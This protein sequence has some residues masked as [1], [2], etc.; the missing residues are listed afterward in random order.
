[1]TDA[2]LKKSVTAAVPASFELLTADEAADRDGRTMTSSLQTLTYAMLGFA[3]VAFLV[4]TF[5]IINT[6]SMLVAQAP[7]RSACCGLSAP[8]DGRSTARC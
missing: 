7:G 1:V 3:G 5:L 2:R 4:G 8:A 6:F